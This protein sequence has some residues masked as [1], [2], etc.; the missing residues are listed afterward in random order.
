MKTRKSLWAA[1]LLLIPVLLAACGG[2][3]QS[4]PMLQPF[5]FYYR[6]ASTDFT[7][8][9]GVLRAEVLDIGSLPYTDADRLD[10]L[11]F[12]LTREPD[13][14]ALVS[15]FSHYQDLIS[16][17]LDTGGT[18][19]LLLRQAPEAPTALERSLAF[20]CLTKTALGLDGV[21]KLSIQ[22]RNSDGQ[23][24]DSIQL[25]DSSILLY[26]SGAMPEVILY[27]ADEE[28]FLIPEARRIRPLSQE[29]LPQFVLELLLG[30]P[31]T[32]GLHSPL[33]PGAE[34]LDVTVENGVCSVD[35]NGDFYANRP[36]GEDAARLAVLSLVNTLCELN[37]IDRVQIYI[38]GQ[39][40]ASYVCQDLSGWWMR[41]ISLVGPIRAQQGEF[42]ARLYLPGQSDP[43]L[44]SL[45]LRARVSG[46]SSKELALVQ[47][48]IS[49]GPQ[50]GLYSPL[51]NAPPPLFVSTRNGVCHVG[52]RAGT[53]PEEP[54]PRL[55]AIRALTATLCALPEIDAVTLTEGD[56][57]V[58]LPSEDGSLSERFSPE[59]DWFCVPPD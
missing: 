46:I 17:R 45:M 29:A 30:G 21:R 11:R 16:C 48:L 32:P 51:E 34:L 2:P 53:L 20:V 42:A 43:L 28:G 37:G 6:T 47:A 50:N 55:Q 27:F 40:Y 36:A 12:Y 10:L 8:E 19:E 15:P 35:F 58:S 7:A 54:T 24:T 22:V 49:R 18:L 44:H 56:V 39:S 26:D 59:P 13:S 5:S 33:P 52:L 3:E 57:P 25:M 38:E 1:I 23:V 4:A 9:D 41:D 14:D 31:Q